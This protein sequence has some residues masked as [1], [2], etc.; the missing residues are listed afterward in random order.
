VYGVNTTIVAGANA[1]APMLGASIAVGWGLRAIFVVA[2][3]LFAVGGF[4]A[5]WVIPSS[6]PAACRSK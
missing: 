5:L 6:A 1:F 2:A 4:F 3:G